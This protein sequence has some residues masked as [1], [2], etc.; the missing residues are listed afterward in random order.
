[1]A[2][3]YA[4]GYL[5]A[6]HDPG[7]TRAAV[8]LVQRPVGCKPKMAG[9]GG[10]CSA[11]HRMSPNSRSDGSKCVSMTRRAMSARP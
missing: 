9:P 5:S 8:G 3:A 10:Y 2:W 1:M 4:R 11:C 6:E 7:G